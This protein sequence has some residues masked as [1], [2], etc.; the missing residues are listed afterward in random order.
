MLPT[1]R[2]DIS[3]KVLIFSS[4]SLLLLPGNYPSS[5][6]FVSQS[7]YNIEVLDSVALDAQV[8]SNKI[9]FAWYLQDCYIQLVDS[10]M[11]NLQQ[12]IRF[13]NFNV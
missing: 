5:R 11:Q 6:M 9:L 3:T 4:D 7:C 10:S 1:V 2:M 13:S 12:R 8:F